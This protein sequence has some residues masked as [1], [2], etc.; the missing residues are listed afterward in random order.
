MDKKTKGFIAVL[1][2]VLMVF[3]V[4]GG[5]GDSDSKDVVQT[6]TEDKGESRNGGENDNEQKGEPTVIVFGHHRIQERDSTYRDPVTGEPT[7][8]PEAFEANKKAREEV[9]DKLNV[10][11]KYIKWPGP[12]GEVLLQSVLANDPLCDIALCWGGSQITLLSQNIIQRLDPYEDIFTSD[13]DADWMYADPVYGGRYFMNFTRQ[14]I[15]WWPLVYNIQYIERV[16]ALKENGE[17]VYPTDLWKRGEWTWSKFEEYLSKLK[18]YY[19]NKQAPVRP[20]KIIHPFQTD[21]RFTAIQAIH[22]NGGVL[23]GPNGFEGD[24]D[25][26]KQAVGY[27]ESLF[28]KGLC[29]SVNYAN[30]PVPGW[31]WSTNDFGNGET[32]FTNITTWGG[33]GASK[34]LLSRG[35]S[36]GI[37]PFPRPDHMAADDPGYRHPGEPRDQAIVLKG[38]PEER[39]RLAIEA[40]KLYMQTYYKAMGNTDKA[41]DYLDATAETVA[42]NFYGL[43]IFHE[44]TG[45]DILDA[46]KSITVDKPN[47]YRVLIPWGGYW[48]KDILGNA[49]WQMEGSPKYAVAVEEK[50]SRIFEMEEE[51]RN[52]LK[53]GEYRD[54]IAPKLKLLVPELAFPKGTDPS[55]IKWEEYVEAVDG[56]DGN[57]DISAG[58]IE[59]K[60]TDFNKIGKGKVEITVSDLSDNEAKKA[61]DIFI[62]DPDNTDAPV[63]VVKEEYEKLAVDADVSE[64]KWK[65]FID[66]AVDKDNLDLKN[67]IK[68]DISELDITTAGTYNVEISVSDFAGNEAKTIIEVTVEDKE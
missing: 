48:N 59:L 47:E 45:D 57:I 53:S 22:S 67:R 26:A 12:I 13:P 18:E 42:L 1:S 24:S 5:C 9:L 44:K 6:E 52:I 50:K 39:T 15:P 43:D 31:T 2:A 61:F 51:I 23:A 34:K 32:V 10:E 64:I 36:M 20:E 62:Y 29:T 37:I 60:D 25:A 27:I 49:I 21:Y 7:M 35:E 40:Y 28:A 58:T 41:A 55:S 46:F 56:I 68:A 66:K 11:V 16:E 3:A 65:N 4:L 33:R 17:T 30:S 63:L 54:N 8:A 19:Q 38:T 14:H